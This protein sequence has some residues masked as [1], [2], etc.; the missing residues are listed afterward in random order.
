MSKW[1]ILT[2]L[3][4]LPVLVAGGFLWGT[5]NASDRLHKVEAAVVNLDEAVTIDG[6]IIPLGRQLS[7]NLVDG[8][9]AENFTWVLA[10]RPPSRCERRRSPAWPTA[11]W[12]R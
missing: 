10:G 7:A 6:Q 12:A 4:L 9:R 2:A 8:E 3:I 1:K 5:W 11:R